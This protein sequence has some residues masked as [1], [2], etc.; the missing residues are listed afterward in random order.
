MSGEP[1]EYKYSRLNYLEREFRLVEL[2]PGDGPDE[3]RC[4]LFTASL[5]N[6]PVFEALS[7]AWGDPKDTRSIHV[8]DQNRAV[9][10]NLYS[11]LL[12]IRGKSQSRV[13]W[14]DALCIDQTN[15]EEKSHQVGLMGDIYK[16]ARETVIWL[17][18]PKTDDNEP[19]N[20]DN[21]SNSTSSN[22]SQGSLHQYVVEWGCGKDNEILKRFAQNRET[23]RQWPVYGAVIL[24]KYLSMD[25]HFDKLPFFPPGS[26]PSMY[27]GE[28]W[29]KSAQALD[30][31]LRVPYWRRTWIIQ[32]AVL[33]TKA[34]VY[35]GAHIIPLAVLLLAQANLNE[36]YHGCCSKWGVDAH[37]SRFT[38]WT[39]FEEN[40]S[41]LQHMAKLVVARHPSNESGSGM[42]IYDVVSGGLDRRQATDPRDHIYGLLG[43]VTKWGTE[44][45]VP[46]YSLTVSQVY[47][48][49]AFKIMKDSGSLFLLTWNERERNKLLGLPSWA[50]DW[51]WHGLFNPN[52]YPWSFFDAAKGQSAFLELRRDS[53][54]AVRGVRVDR[55]SKIGPVRTW[56]WYPPQELVKTMKHWRA[57]AGIHDQAGSIEDS[58]DLDE[59]FWRVVFADTI[60]SSQGRRATLG[61]IDTIRAW[62]AW[63]QS[64]SG[65][66]SLR[67]LSQET[68]AKGLL[69]GTKPAMM[70][71]GE[72]SEWATLPC[73]EKFHNIMKTFHERTRSR[74]F[75]LTEGGRMGTGPA[76]IRDGNEVLLGDEIYILNGSKVPFVL[77]PVNAALVSE[78]G[79][80]DRS[81]PGYSLIGT[82]Y[83]HGV[84]DGEVLNSLHAETQI[85][86]LH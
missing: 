80:A 14:V 30:S 60:D 66:S 15:V 81:V 11:A 82:C 56:E 12:R 85:I 21:A 74:K 86:D 27:P 79:K 40:M 71:G 54:L 55:V 77:R 17:G 37:G 83:V 69:F 34:R 53:V 16:T 36:H 45:I 26:D 73:P 78:A 5:N 47:A 72:T 84:M 68:M 70:L 62:W 24:L 43:L 32:E 2:L 13:I 75:L 9:T 50:N 44:R 57:I 39:S 67:E 58:Q 33:A 1:H 48:R 59:R 22:S 42:T 7:Y 61:D 18:E 52:P 4:R 76:T 6:S 35:Y 28:I 31:L 64:T 38:F 19:S 20:S 46:D 10:I 51:S 3:V 25:V 41:T 65:S 23:L 29:I 63:L 8:N 49:T